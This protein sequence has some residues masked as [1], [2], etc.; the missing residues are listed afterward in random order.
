ADLMH[1]GY[2]GV[3]QLAGD[4]RLAEEAL[5]RDRIGWVALGQ[6]LDGDVAIKG[7]IAGAMDDTHA[8]VADLVEQLVA[9]RICGRSA[10]LDD[11]VLARSGGEWPVINH[12]F[13]VPVLR[14]SPAVGPTATP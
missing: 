14:Q 5:G 3:L 10:R 2:A 6:Q 4:A 1:S 13:P 12:V 9:R 7:G 11:G 8:P